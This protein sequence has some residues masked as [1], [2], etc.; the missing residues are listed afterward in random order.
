MCANTCTFV[1]I[2]YYVYVRLINK[3]EK[4]NVLEQARK[5]WFDTWVEQ[6]REDIGSCTLGNCI[7]TKAGKV[8]SPPVQGNLS[9]YRS[10][11]KA[12]EFLNKQGLSASYYDGVM[13]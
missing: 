11:D 5:I 12:I 13:D 6:G 4:M 1:H 7:I 9:K 10:A 3:G 2:C 8:P